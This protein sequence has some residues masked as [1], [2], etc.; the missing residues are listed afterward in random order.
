MCSLQDE[1]SM[2]QDLQLCRVDDIWGIGRR[3]SVNFHN[4]GT[5]TAFDLKKVDP[6]WMRQHY[7]VMGEHIVRELNGVALYK[8]NS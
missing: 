7:T 5:H 2:N 3:L 6:R 4:L 1:E 8:I